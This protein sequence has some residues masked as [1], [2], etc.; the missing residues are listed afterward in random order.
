MDDRELSSMKKG[1]SPLRNWT[2]DKVGREQ[3]KELEQR[4]GKKRRK[5]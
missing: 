2:T 4:K 1:S 5:R 3:K